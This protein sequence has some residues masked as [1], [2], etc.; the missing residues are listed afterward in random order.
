MLWTTIV[1][2]QFSQ[3]TPFDNVV[4]LDNVVSISVVEFCRDLTDGLKLLYSHRFTRPWWSNSNF[5]T[6]VLP[7]S[8]AYV[9]IG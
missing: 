5:S 8:L 3:G 2:I 9:C 6:T 4:S 1:R 7:T